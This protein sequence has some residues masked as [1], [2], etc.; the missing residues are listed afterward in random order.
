[1]AA[2]TTTPLASLPPLLSSLRTTFESGKTK[3]I[4]FRKAQ[5]KQF[6]KLVDENE[7]TLR[8]ALLK[9]VGKPLVESAGL[10]L[11][12]FKNEVVFMLESLDEWLAPEN[13]MVPQI[14]ESFNATIYKQPK[15]CCLVIG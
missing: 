1:M 8:D 6:W 5:L 14:F 2:F 7:P 10:E 15:G 11:S 9:D 13:P 3:D 12:L 4:E